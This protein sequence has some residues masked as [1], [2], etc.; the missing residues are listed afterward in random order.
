MS[1]LFKNFLD[2]FFIDFI[3]EI[4]YSIREKKKHYNNK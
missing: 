1:Y 3:A 2:D 4:I